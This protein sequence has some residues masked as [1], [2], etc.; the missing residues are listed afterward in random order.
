MGEG[1]AGLDFM[2]DQYPFAARVGTIDLAAARVSFLA[3]GTEP[4]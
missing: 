4:L 1:A 3:S 2:T